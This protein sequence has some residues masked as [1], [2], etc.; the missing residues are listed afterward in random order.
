ME[1]G[2]K[3]FCLRSVRD[4]MKKV[5]PLAFALFTLFAS[6][7]P[8]YIFL[9]RANEK[10]EKGDKTGALS[11]LN[12]AIAKDPR[13]F[14]SLHARAGFFARSGKKEL[15]L[16]DWDKALSVKPGNKEVLVSRA[17]LFMATK[18]RDKA[19][20][21]L[22]QVIKAGASGTRAHELRAMIRLE[23]G[24]EDKAFEDFEEAIKVGQLSAKA[25]R[26]AAIL[27]QKRGSHADAIKCFSES[28]RLDLGE[29]ESLTGMAASYLALGGKDHAQK[30][31]AQLTEY[32]K[33]GGSLDA[34]FYKTRYY[35]NKEAANLPAAGE[36]LGV[37]LDKLKVKDP[38]LQQERAKLSIQHG[39]SS[40]ALKQV[41]KV[42]ASDRDNKEMLLQRAEIYFRQGKS[43][44]PMAMSDLKRLSE[45]SSENYVVW[46]L[47]TLIQVEENKWEPA[48]QTAMQWVK[49]KPEAEAYYVR[50]K[51]HYRLKNLKACCSDLDKAAGMGHTE[52]AK[53]KSVVC[54]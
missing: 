25:W 29:K 30:G 54:R 42:L 17:E 48:L 49:Y 40:D 28:A 47:M 11:D 7:Q 34:Q 19:I 1:T 35:L 16:S 37:L 14:E 44:Y 2:Y 4:R 24:E 12:A 53:D 15:A 5:L 32:E 26:N 10:L 18:D 31:L 21:D 8:A 27:R 39:Q 3:L 51:C 20:T 52:A 22:N 38:A 9:Q 13:H 23:A 36:D 43:K 45:L 50:S 33:R 6:A 41:N 46:R